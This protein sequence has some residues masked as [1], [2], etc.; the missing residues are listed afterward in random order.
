MNDHLGKPF[1]GAQ[2]LSHLMVWLKPQ[3]VAAEPI[4]NESQQGYVPADTPVAIEAAPALQ[5]HSLLIVDDQPAN[6]KV[7]ANLLKN[8]YMIQ[9]A[10]NGKKALEIA[11]GKS[12]PD[13]ILL[14]IMMPEMDGYTVCRELKSDV[15][16]SKIPVIFIT[17]LDEAA[18]E[19]K[20]LDLGAADYISKP[21][22][23]EIVKARVRNHM[24]LKIRTDLLEEMSHLD[25]LTRIANRR[26]L[27]ATLARELK[28]HV[29]NKNP[30]GLVM[31]DI[32]YF[33]PYND[34]YGHGKG[35]ECLIRVAAALQQ[36]I[37]RPGDLLG[38]YGGEEFV[39]VLPDTDKAGVLK[40]ANAL[41]AA[42]TAIN[43]PHEFSKVA[44]HVTISV[45]AVAALMVNDESALG[46]LK[47]ADSALYE[48]KR[49]GRNRVV[50]L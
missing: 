27:D 44:D 29:R 30:L 6:I 38:R 26:H 36:T 4:A 21:F 47:K 31:L 12:P 11:R 16:S 40:M 22:H 13:L 43:C 49:Q 42:V 24:S 32:D 46:L 28:R 48:A 3:N 35:D 9:V 45:G 25:G 19:A 50:V 14:D 2:L 37:Q 33:K 17:A 5:K 10:N 34:N 8:D 18:N 41:R 15:A 23:N 7:L 39:V 20:G 1:S